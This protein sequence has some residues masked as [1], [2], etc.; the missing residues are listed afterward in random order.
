MVEA[1]LTEVDDPALRERL[2]TLKV[3]RG[4]LNSQIASLQ[5]VDS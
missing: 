5:T 4:A 2:S 3:K 1:D